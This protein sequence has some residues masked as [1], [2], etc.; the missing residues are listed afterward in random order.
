MVRKKRLSFVE[1]VRECWKWASMQFQALTL[2]LL[3]AWAALPEKLQDA[4]PTWA[5]VTVA[6]VLLVFGMIGRVTKVD[7]K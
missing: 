3:G 6:I 7:D 2:A 5:V 4:V 1:N